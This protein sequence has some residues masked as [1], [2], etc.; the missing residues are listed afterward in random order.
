MRTKK[1]G[2]LGSRA[3]KGKPKQERRL[4]LEPNTGVG[5]GGKARK[6]ENKKKR[7]RRCKVLKGTKKPAEE[8]E[9]CRAAG[10]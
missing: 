6:R 4:H 3:M 5:E 8:V 10:A 2:R 9:G 1:V 7:R